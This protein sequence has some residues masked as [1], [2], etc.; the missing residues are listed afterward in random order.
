MGG[1][2]RIGAQGLGGMRARGHQRRCESKEDAC[3]EGK[4]KSKADDHWRRRSTDRHVLLIRKGERQQRVCSEIGDGEAE[5]AAHTRQKN[6]FGQE[7][8]HKSAALRAQCRADG[9]FR[10][11]AHAAHQ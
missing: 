2:T 5:Q 9:K 8:A 7:L 1:C 3:D 11:P 10:A 4:R 6:A